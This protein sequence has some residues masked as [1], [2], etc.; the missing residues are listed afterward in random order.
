MLTLGVGVTASC[1][2]QRQHD[3]QEH[4]VASHQDEQAAHQYKTLLGRHVYIYEG[5]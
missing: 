5:L 2:Y 1:H 4:G 3:R